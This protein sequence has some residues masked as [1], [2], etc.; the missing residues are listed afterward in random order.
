MH[1]PLVL[2]QFST[3]NQR[4]NKFSHLQAGIPY[5]LPAFFMEFRANIKRLAISCSCSLPRRQLRN[6]G[7]SA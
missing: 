5:G 2:T 1:R 3:H 4:G 7:R 6:I